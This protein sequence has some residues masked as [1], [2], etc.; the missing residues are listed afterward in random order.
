[1]MKLSMRTRTP[2]AMALLAV[3]IVSLAAASSVA[4]QADTPDG[5][6]FQTCSVRVLNTTTGLGG[7]STELQ[8]GTWYD[9]PVAGVGNIPSSGVS[10]I[11]ASLTVLDESAS[12]QLY[13]APAGSTPADPT[14][15][16]SYTGS[17]S[18]TN[19]QTNDAFL[20]L[21]QGDIEIEA[22]A[23]TDVII[24]VHGYFTSGSVAPGG[25][26]TTT[27]TTVASTADGTGGLPQA[28][29]AT[30]STATATISG[31][32]V[33]PTTA[34]AAMIE[35]L[36]S[37]ASGTH[38]GRLFVGPSAYGATTE[39]LDWPAQTSFDW[40]TSVD[41]SSSS[42][43]TINVDVGGPVDVQVVV[44][45]YVT[46]G[47][48]GTAMGGEFTASVVPVYDSTTGDGVLASGDQRV[49]T[50]AGYSPIP[51]Q[52]MVAAVAINVLVTPVTSSDTGQLS[53]YSSDDTSGPALVS[54][55]GVPISGATVVNVGQDSN[56]VVQNLGSG[57]ANV[58]VIVQGWFSPMTPFAGAS[59][60]SVDC[61]S[62]GDSVSTASLP[63]G[64]DPDSASNA[65]LIA[66]GLPPRPTDPDYVATWQAF[67]D[68]YQ[69]T[70]PVCDTGQ[71][72]LDSTNPP[73]T[74]QS[75]PAD[76][77]DGVDNAVK[78]TT[79]GS[80]FCSPNWDGYVATSKRYRVASATFRIPTPGADGNH[81]NARSSQWVGLG[82]G[83][84]GYP[85]VQGGSTATGTVGVNAS[86]TLW[87]QVC[88]KAPYTSH[89]RTAVSSGTGSAGAGDQVSVVI[90]ASSN[91]AKISLSDETPHH[92]EYFAQTY[93][94]KL[95][96]L[97]DQ[98]AEWIDERQSTQS[99]SGLFPYLE[100]TG[101][102]KFDYAGASTGSFNLT[103]VGKLPHYLNK[104]ETCKN[105]NLMAH[106]SSISSDNWSFSAIWD[107]YGDDAVCG[108]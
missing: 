39:P 107:S 14:A 105:H 69:P 9:V 86:E 87:W 60:A 30:G 95:K 10:A 5:G 2:R 98:K 80:N 24:D 67:V 47:S 78:C 25:Y 1:M 19:W 91:L 33:V 37:G 52:Q 21:G 104:M 79:S 65:Q 15:F 64:F 29:L 83:Q 58:Q 56:I 75:A 22:S 3:T 12:G 94:W 72:A 54:Y 13:A 59:Y 40:T 92:G 28:Q 45:G 7:Y 27:P 62:T 88:C 26:I 100:K 82:D 53:V 66:N 101:P 31:T 61:P 97:P 50:V 70:S 43:V 51:D 48:T 90:Q 108:P 57:S 84:N 46:S 76:G 42:G 20:G 89:M 34:S 41:L 38:R 23:P 44:L 55:N 6:L 49:I 85:L 71:T 11:D 106:V 17:T 73:V 93:K 4:V 102:V 68:N 99:E 35:I 63:T 96:S 18:G 74:D 32:S 36:V 16:V 103:P 81:T 8:P 77:T